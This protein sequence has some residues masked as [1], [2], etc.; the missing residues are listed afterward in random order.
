MKSVR[1]PLSRRKFHKRARLR[2]TCSGPALLA[3]AFAIGCGGGGGHDAS[4]PEVGTPI[5]TLA[6]VVNECREDAS[7]F[8]GR[9]RLEVRRGGAP[10]GAVLEFPWAGAASG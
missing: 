6:Y 1:V 8:Y 2:S 7:G 10:P 4:T 5:G 9:Q 3:I